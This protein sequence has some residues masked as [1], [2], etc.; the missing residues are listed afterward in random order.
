VDSL[1]LD[2]LSLLIGAAPDELLEFC[3]DMIHALDLRFHNLTGEERDQIILKVMLAVDDDQIAK[4]GEGRLPDWENGWMSNLAEFE[5]QKGNIDMLIPKYFKKNVPIRLFGDY[6]KPVGD[7]FVLGITKVFRGWLFKKYF[8]SVDHIHEFGCGSEKQL[9]GY[10][11]TNAS[12]KI[13]ETLV[14]YY[15]WNIHDKHFDFINPDYSIRLAPKSGIYTFAALEQIGMDYECYLDFLLKKSPDICINIEP[16][17]ELYDTSNLVDY[18][19]LR[20]HKH[21]NYLYGYLSR[22]KELESENRIEILKVYHQRF[23]NLYNDTHSYIIWR[24]V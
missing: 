6:V 24:P 14:K 7:D 22:L 2:K 18:L 3:G 23:G 10:D 9:Y 16:L 11:W 20:Y 5:T 1:T 17:H 12:Q 8:K 21:R 15:G 4:A 19:A 13:L